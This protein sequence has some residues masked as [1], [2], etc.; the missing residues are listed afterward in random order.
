MCLALARSEYQGRIVK[1]L[2]EKIGLGS[3]LLPRPECLL[4]YVPYVQEM[5]RGM[6][7]KWRWMSPE[8]C[9]V[10]LAEALISSEEG[11]A[12]RE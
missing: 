5:V 12:G 6:Q 10:L 9:R 7:G 2:D 11:L 3:A 1:A 8:G 4:D